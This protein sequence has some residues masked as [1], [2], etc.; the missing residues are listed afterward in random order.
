MLSEIS[1]KRLAPQPALTIAM[2]VKQDEIGNAMHEILP[3]VFGFIV[4]RSGQPAGPPF[5]RYLAWNADGTTDL[6]AGFPV[7]APLIPEGRVQACELPEGE[8]AMVV[9]SGSYETL[10]DAYAA[11]GAW[12]RTEH[13]ET[14]GPP[15]E[16]YVTDPGT[17][18]DSSKWQ[19][20]VYWPV[21]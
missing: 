1:L 11:L 19:T 17:E 6:E 8:A 12:V 15:W 9:H 3:E 21:R 18:P 16:I 20:E 10:G 13:R 5:T 2:S 7:V 14:A 4:A